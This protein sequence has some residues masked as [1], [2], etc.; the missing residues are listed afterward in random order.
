[1]RL[2]ITDTKNNDQPLAYYYFSLHLDDGVNR[3]NQTDTAWEAHPVQIAGG[4]NFRQVD[5]HTYEGMEPTPTGQA[6]LTLSQP[7]GAGVKIHITARMRSVYAT[8]AKD[9]ILP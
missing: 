5:A 7:G 2:A 9:V 4:S 6:S 1:M 3:K 8:D